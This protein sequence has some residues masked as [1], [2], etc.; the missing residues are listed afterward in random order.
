LS[1]VSF[2]VP[3]FCTLLNTKV[4][5]QVAESCRHRRT[6]IRGPT[7]CDVWFPRGP[8]FQTQGSSCNVWAVLRLTSLLLFYTFPVQHAIEWLACTNVKHS[9]RKNIKHTVIL[10][11]FSNCNTSKHNLFFLLIPIYLQAVQIHSANGVKLLETWR[12]VLSS[13]PPYK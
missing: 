1:S 9:D 8:Q 12:G 10:K 6:T 2:F 13:T 5:A 4:S 7:C 11:P 3:P